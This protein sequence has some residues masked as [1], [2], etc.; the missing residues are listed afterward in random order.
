MTPTSI[1]HIDGDGFFAS[2]EQT[3]HP[4]LAGIPVVTG[5]ERGIITSASKEA[6]QLGIG[7]GV[8][9]WDAKKMC[10]E[11]VFAK[12]DYLSYEL[13]SYRMAGILRAHCPSVEHYSVD[14]AFADITG[15]PGAWDDGALGLAG[16]AKTDV[17]QGLGLTVSVGVGRTKTLAKVGSKWRKPDGLTVIAPGDEAAYLAKTHVGR[18]WGVGPMTA[19]K[20]LGMGVGTALEL[21]RLP[22]RLVE[23]QFDAPLAATWTEL[24]GEMVHRVDSGPPAPPKSLMR[25][26]TFRPASAEREVIERELRHNLEQALWRLRQAGLAARRVG[27]MV[28]RQADFRLEFHDVVLPRASAWDAEFAP[29]V[30]PALD[31]M[32]RP[33]ILYRASGVVL[34]DLAPMSTGQR[35]IFDRPEREDRLRSV[36]DGLDELRRKY[37][38]PLVRTG[39]TSAAVIDRHSLDCLRPGTLLPAAPARLGTQRLTFL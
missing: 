20:L 8:T 18:I 21:A 28:K 31:A 30:E 27:F 15:M 10:P 32:L 24:R 38:R 35:S 19:K 22:E 9:P 34:Q 3:M 11:L 12:S 16:R 39:T 7:R 26:R 13:F 37:R 17:T 36:Y 25:T 33:R 1:L 29:F 2:C 14:E 4:E 23:T 5:S 6:K